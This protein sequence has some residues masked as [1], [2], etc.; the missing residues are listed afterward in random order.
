[1]MNMRSFCFIIAFHNPATLKNWLI[2]LCPS[3]W[4][5]VITMKKKLA[6]TWKKEKEKEKEDIGLSK[7]M[8]TSLQ[9]VK[10]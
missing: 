5:V 7:L 2:Y 1:M 10:S 6:S 8:A 3:S 4:P 9:L